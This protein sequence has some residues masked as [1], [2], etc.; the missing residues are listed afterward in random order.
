MK[1]IIDVNLP[2]RWAEVLQRHGIDSVHWTAVGD[3]RATDG[4][5]MEWARDHKHVVFTH[6]LDFGALL[7]MTHATGPSVVQ[8][9]TQDVFPEAIEALVVKVL[10]DYRDALQRGAI[11]SVD[12]VLARVRILPIQP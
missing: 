3:P 7:A 6:D 2:P 8:V 5:I 12:Q 1:I 4:E 9:R 11:V 10:T